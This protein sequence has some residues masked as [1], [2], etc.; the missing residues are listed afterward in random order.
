VKRSAAKLQIENEQVFQQEH[1]RPAR[2]SALSASPEN[3][4]SR[5]A[6][7]ILRARRRR[8]NGG[9]ANIGGS[10][11]FHNQASSNRLQKGKQ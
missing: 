6:I 4:N 3:G 9:V 7:A 1:W 10:N 8:P 11:R 5:D 2:R